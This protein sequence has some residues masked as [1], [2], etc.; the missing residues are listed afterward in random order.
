MSKA[1]TVLVDAGWSPGRRVDARDELAAL[2]AAGFSTAEWVERF[3]REFSGLRLQF[4]RYGRDD[5]I[6]VS[7]KEAIRLWYPDVHGY[8]EARGYMRRVGDELVP[9]GHAS[10]AY[11]LLLRAADGRWFGAFDWTL[12]EIGRS[13]FEAIERIVEGLD[14]SRE[15]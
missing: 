8:T 1:E 10:N 2:A 5:E 13:D 9:I 4:Q 6:V 3:V 11:M 12:G 14:F 7:S 15:Y